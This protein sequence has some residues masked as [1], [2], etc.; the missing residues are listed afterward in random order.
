MRFVLANLE[1]SK[2]TRRIGMGICKCWYAGPVGLECNTCKQA[3]VILQ[4]TCRETMTRENDYDYFWP[5]KHCVSPYEM[6]RLVEHENS[7]FT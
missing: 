1:A 4:T 2:D 5:E 7:I 3:F 6:V